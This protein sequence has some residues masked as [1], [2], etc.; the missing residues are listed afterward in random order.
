[1]DKSTHQIIIEEIKDIVTGLILN[2]ASASHGDF[3][4]NIIINSTY[5][6][7]NLTNRLKLRECNACPENMAA[8]ITIVSLA[9]QA[10]L[11]YQR[12]Q[13]NKWG[14]TIS[15]EEIGC[16]FIATTAPAIITYFQ[17]HKASSNQLNT[18]TRNNQTNNAQAMASAQPVYHEDNTLDSVFRLIKFL[19]N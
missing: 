16:N 10:L 1:M 6:L 12:N 9:I 7:N 19:C 2:Y 15:L 13:E 14:E 17:H 4:A 18:N 3:Y 5:I 11:A 8:A